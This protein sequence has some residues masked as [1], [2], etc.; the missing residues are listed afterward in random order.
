MQLVSA[1]GAGRGYQPW[2]WD[3]LPC[4]PTQKIAV[5]PDCVARELD[6]FVVSGIISVYG[7]SS[8]GDGSFLGFSRVREHSG[9][10]Q[11]RHSDV[12]AVVF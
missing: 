10:L 1:L 3:K 7:D 11:E 6:K 12:D 8:V 5:H 4:V 9:A 2:V